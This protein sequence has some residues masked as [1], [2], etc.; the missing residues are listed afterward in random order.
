MSKQVK[1]VEGGRGLLES[2]I[3]QH[4]DSVDT[5]SEKHKMFEQ[6]SVGLHPDDCKYFIDL[7]FT[8][9]K[10]EQRETSEP[11]PITLEDYNKT[12][13]MW[14]RVR[15]TEYV[16]SKQT[17]KIRF[18][19]KRWRQSTMPDNHVMSEIMSAWPPSEGGIKALKQWTKRVLAKWT[20]YSLP[21]VVSLNG[22]VTPP[23]HL[24]VTAQWTVIKF[25]DKQRIKP[26]SFY[27]CYAL[28]DESIDQRYVLWS[29]YPKGVDVP[30]VEVMIVETREEGVR[31]Y[32]IT[33]L[34]I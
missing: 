31:K 4:L 7:F 20:I 12:V 26:P 23:A 28:Y 5:I 32:A 33:F 34:R 9:P 11:Q 27:R 29:E 24:Q 10:Q 1:L 6:I 25:F 15:Q 13:P 16:A 30:E 21:D 3:R 22:I 8:P 17:C 2:Y 14:M 19:N 18:V